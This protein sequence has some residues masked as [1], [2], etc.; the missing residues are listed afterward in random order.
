MIQKC[1]FKKKTPEDIDKMQ[2]Y[3]DQLKKGSYTWLLKLNTDK[4]STLH[5]GRNS[6]CV[7]YLLGN[8]INSRNLIQNKGSRKRLG[9]TIKY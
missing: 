1:W 6:A 3:S 9:Y 5:Y 8:A 7:T 2:R 4:C